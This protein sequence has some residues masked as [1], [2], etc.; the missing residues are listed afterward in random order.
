[1]FCLVDSFINHNGCLNFV[2]NLSTSWFHDQILMNFFLYPIHC[3]QSKL[4]CKE[5][6]TNTTHSNS[7]VPTLSYVLAD[8]IM[9]SL[10]KFVISLHHS[11]HPWS[12]YR[13]SSIYMNASE[14]LQPTH[15]SQSSL[16]KL[17][18]ILKVLYSLS[19]SLWRYT[20]WK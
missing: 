13:I 12:R 16:A 7:V 17:S 6:P 15:P 18:P 11:F 14:F 3:L 9:W 10:V 1:M 5:Y 4:W 20:T 19:S 8:I 2:L